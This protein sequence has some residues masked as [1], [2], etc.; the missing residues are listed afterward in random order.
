M[1][2]NIEYVVNH[3]DPNNGLTKPLFQI[4][5][6]LLFKETLCP[7]DISRDFI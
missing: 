3:V 5:K 1:I 7:F 2:A 6:A 4:M